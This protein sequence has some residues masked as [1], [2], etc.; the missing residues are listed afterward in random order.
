M[1]RIRWRRHLWMGFA[2][3]ALMVA[4]AALVPLRDVLLLAAGLLVG[5]VASARRART[6]AAVAHEEIRRL[7]RVGN[8]GARGD[9]PADVIMAT[10]AELL[11]LLRLRD[12][13]FEASPFA[14]RYERFERNG[15]VAW[16]ILRL[17]NGGLALPDEGVELPVLGRGQVLGRFVLY[18][19]SGTG[20]SLEQRVVA[21][22]LADQVGA[23]LAAPQPGER[24]HAHG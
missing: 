6:S 22:A 21:V 10:Q 12:C 11:G 3:V 1:D 16:R 4:A 2:A 5:Y 9:D 23:V 18:P 13:R 7:Y 8:L 14:R 20:V 24:R 17:R 15:L 19:R